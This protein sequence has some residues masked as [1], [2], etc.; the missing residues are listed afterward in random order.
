MWQSWKRGKVTRVDG[1]HYIVITTNDVSSASTVGTCTSDTSFIVTTSTKCIC[2]HST[3]VRPS[4]FINS[5]SSSGGPGARGR[6]VTLGPVGSTA[7]AR[8]TLARTRGEKCGRVALLNT[9]NN[10]ISRALT[11]LT[12]ISRTGRQN[13]GLAVVSSRR[14]VFTIGGRD[15]EV[16]HGATGCC[17]SIFSINKSDI[18]SRRNICCPLSSC[19]LSPFS[20]LKI[21]GRVASSRTIVAMGGKAIVVIRTSELWFFIS[22]L[23]GGSCLCIGVVCH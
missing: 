12:L 4:L 23:L 21:D 8:A 2:Y 1:G 9:L 5:C 15:M 20:T 22:C 14:G 11:G 13:A 17:L 10:E 16:R 3:N 6:L 18:V 7:S 19:A